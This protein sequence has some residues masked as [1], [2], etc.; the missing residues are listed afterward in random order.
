MHW[1]PA[2]TLKVVDGLLEF[3]CSAPRVSRHC[4]FLSAG[5]W[6]PRLGS[7]ALAKGALNII[8]KG[9]GRLLLSTRAIEILCDPTGAATGVL[10]ENADGGNQ[11]KLH[12]PIIIS[13]G[14]LMVVDR[15]TGLMARQ[16]CDQFVHFRYPV[17]CWCLQHVPEAASPSTASGTGK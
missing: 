5:T 17:S 15:I 3:K 16:D 14:L 4:F 10:V 9:G 6:Y 2:T 1:L 11:R 8:Q 13:G 12:A 7:R